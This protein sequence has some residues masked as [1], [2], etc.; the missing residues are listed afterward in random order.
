M[1]FALFGCFLGRYGQ[2]LGIAQANATSK[3]AMRIYTNVKSVL[4]IKVENWAE[5]IYRKLE[6]HGQYQEATEWVDVDKAFSLKLPDRIMAYKLGHR[7]QKPQYK[8]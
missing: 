6:P 4:L 8:P 2:V 7:M 1:G 5:Q 3:I